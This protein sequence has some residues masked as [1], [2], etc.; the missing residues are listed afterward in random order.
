MILSSFLLTCLFCG[1]V[2]EFMAILRAGKI[3]KTEENAL[4]LLGYVIGNI[5]LLFN[6]Y[7]QWVGVIIFLLGVISGYLKEKYK[8]YNTYRIIDCSICLTLLIYV[9]TNSLILKFI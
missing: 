9:I 5:A 8:F 7:Y 1:I 4:I 6:P 2:Y 3:I